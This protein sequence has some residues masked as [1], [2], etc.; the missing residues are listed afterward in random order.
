[1]SKSYAEDVAARSE[2]YV[3]VDALDDALR[4]L[5][6]RRGVKRWLQTAFDAADIDALIH[7]PPVVYLHSDTVASPY[8]SNKTGD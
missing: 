1:M 3:S 5:M 7:E 2:K 8:S 6:G 4:R